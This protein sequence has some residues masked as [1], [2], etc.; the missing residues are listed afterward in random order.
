MLA[1]VGHALACGGSVVT[2]RV[3]IG[4]KE[5]GEGGG[6]A[7]WLGKPKRNKSSLDQTGSK[8]SKATRAK[9]NVTTR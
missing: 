7:C 8:T 5:V 4:G 2:R 9:G 3:A 1:R 6:E